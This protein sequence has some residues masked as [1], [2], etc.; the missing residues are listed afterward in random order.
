MQILNYVPDKGDRRSNNVY[1]CLKIVFLHLHSYIQLHIV[2]FAREY[3]LLSC[4]NPE[5]RLAGLLLSYT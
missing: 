1:I 2:P 5:S 3:I 4:V